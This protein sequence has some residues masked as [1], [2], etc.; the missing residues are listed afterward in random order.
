MI[1][2][3]IVSPVLP[4]LFSSFSRMQHDLNHLLG[5]FL[6][7]LKILAMISFPI[8]G[9]AFILQKQLAACI[10]GPKWSGMEFVISWMGLMHGFSWLFVANPELYR[11]LGRPDINTK[12]MLIGICYYVPAY[13]ISVRYGLAVFV[14]TRVVVACI[15]FPIHIYVVHK[16][17]GVR[18]RDL[19][20]HI[21]YALIATIGM[22]LLVSW[23][24]TKMILVDNIWGELV[25]YTCIG[26]AIYGILLFREWPFMLNF[27]YALISK[28]E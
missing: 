22:M 28:A 14:I 27:V 6:K 15:G 25:V 3:M 16:F 9:G 23:C 13:L 8:G 5:V 17:L 18:L 11:A 7:V 20:Q 19:W 21:K 12:I 10:F 4:V 2:G 26:A 1:F 24:K